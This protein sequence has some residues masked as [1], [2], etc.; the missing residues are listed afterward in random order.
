MVLF[1]DLEKQMIAALHVVPEDL[2]GNEQRARALAIAKEHIQTARM[3]AVRAV[4]NAPED[5]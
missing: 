4:V 3:W 2:G 5:A 1:K